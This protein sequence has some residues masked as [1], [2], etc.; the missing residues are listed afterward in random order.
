MSINIVINGFFG[1]MGQAI[2]SESLKI[3]DAEV[4]AGCDSKISSKDTAIE[5]TTALLDIKSTFDVVIDFSIASA[6]SNVLSECVK[7]GKPLVIGTTGHNDLQISNIKEC[8]LSIPILHAPNMS[9]GVNT[10]LSAIEEIARTLKSYSIHI[11][12]IHHKNKLDSP[13]GTA[14]KLANVI[15]DSRGE[16]LGDIKNE[17]CPVKFTSIREDVAIGTHEVTFKGEKDSIIVSHI[18]ND[19]SIF[20]NG[21]IKTAIWL[22]AQ[23]PG[24]YSYQDYLDSL[25]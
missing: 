1:K 7:L 20:A 19:R 2:L 18:A 15:C 22:S 9:I 4:V 11:K 8:S 16:N 23:K 12:E 21:S 25:S 3:R 14:L 6:T 5:T 17:N 24:F 10:V 13:S